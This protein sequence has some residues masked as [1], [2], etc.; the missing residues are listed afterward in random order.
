MAIMFKN[1]PC[2]GSLSLEQTL[3]FKLVPEI[4]VCLDADGK[5]YLCLE[6]SVP[7]QWLIGRIDTKALVRVLKDQL[8]LY[9]AIRNCALKGIVT[10]L[11]GKF[12]F[13]LGVPEDAYPNGDRMLGLWSFDEGVHEYC[14]KLQMRL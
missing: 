13:A 2:I 3:Y 6:H 14:E 9:Q 5:R 7:G 4:F 10:G 12:S 1:I 8:P 11:L